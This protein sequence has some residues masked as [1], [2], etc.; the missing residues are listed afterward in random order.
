MPKQKKQLTRKKAKTKARGKADIVPFLLKQ[1]LGNLSNKQKQATLKTILFNLPKQGVE[2]AITQQELAIKELAEEPKQLFQIT[3]LPIYNYPF[4]QGVPRGY[5]Y[6]YPLVKVMGTLR[7]TD[8]VDSIYSLKKDAELQEYPKHFL[9]TLFANFLKLT[10]KRRK[11]GDDYILVRIP[12]YELQQV[13]TTNKFFIIDFDFLSNVLEISGP[14][15]TTRGSYSGTSKYSKGN[16]SVNAYKTKKFKSYN[17]FI[18]KKI[19]NTIFD[20]L[21]NAYRAY[22][23][24]K[25]SSKIMITYYSTLRGLQPGLPLA[26]YINNFP[27]E[28]DEPNLSGE[29]RRFKDVWHLTEVGK[30][31][32]KNAL[33]DFA[34]YYEA[35][36]EDEPRYTPEVTNVHVHDVLTYYI[37]ELNRMLEYLANYRI[38]IVRELLDAI[39]SDMLYID[40]K[41]DNLYGPDVIRGVAPQITI[42]DNHR[43]YYRIEIPD[44]L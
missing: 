20:P 9:K 12:D 33:T 8:L 28:H 43:P 36:P 41:I 7:E 5:E 19:K 13:L 4:Q 10:K 3:P 6:N 17:E 26:P 34:G 2:D 32:Y 1:K 27:I 15:L 11:D 42:W 31:K 30:Q 22:W 18:I 40:N 14:K 39:N 24:I 16:A 38:S 35:Q 37:L 25:H 21:I 29:L 44:L 23:A